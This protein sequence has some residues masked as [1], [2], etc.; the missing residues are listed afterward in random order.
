MDGDSGLNIMYLEML[1]AMGIARSHIRLNGAPFHGIVPGKRAKSV[2]RSTCPSLSELR[3]TSGTPSRW[4]TSRGVTKP[5]WGGRV[6]RSSWPYLTT[7]TSSSRCRAM[8]GHHC[9][10]LVPVCLWV[11]G[12]VRRARRGDHRLPGEDRGHQGDGRWGHAR[13]KAPS[14]DIHAHRRHQG[15]HPRP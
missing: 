15:S 13:R 6:M 10:Y 1:D 12:G 2:G 8:R 3:P 9:R 4:L 5:S 11:R 7:P 14:Q